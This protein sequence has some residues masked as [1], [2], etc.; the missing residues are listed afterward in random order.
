MMTPSNRRVAQ[1][2]VE[3]H[4]ED[5]H[6]GVVEHVEGKQDVD[7]DDDNDDDDN[8]DDDDD[9]DEDDDDDDDDDEHNERIEVMQI[10]TQ[11]RE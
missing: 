4:V 10:L 8:E 3:E 11:S 5:E 9:D 6:Q 2:V 7:D 1:R